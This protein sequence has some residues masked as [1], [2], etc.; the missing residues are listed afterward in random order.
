MRFNPKHSKRKHSSCVR[1]E[2]DVECRVAQGAFVHGC[3]HVVTQT[4]PFGTKSEQNQFIDITWVTRFA[5]GISI[6]LNTYEL[7]VPY[8]KTLTAIIFVCLRKYWLLR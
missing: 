3:V 7:S 6:T 8:A 1:V 2:R 5:K 4:P